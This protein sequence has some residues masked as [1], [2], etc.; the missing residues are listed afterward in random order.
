MSTGHGLHTEQ[1]SWLIAVDANHTTLAVDVFSLLFLSQ[2]FEGLICLEI[3]AAYNKSLHHFK[4]D[5][6]RGR[7]KP[8]Y[9]VG[10]IFHQVVQT[11]EDVP[12]ISVKATWIIKIKPNHLRYY[13][14]KSKTERRIC[15]ALSIVNG[16]DPMIVL[17]LM[18]EV[19][20]LET[21]RPFAFIT[22]ATIMLLSNR[23][24]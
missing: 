22:M 24:S 13:K 23:Q 18:L 9:S 1:G 19:P 15:D 12:G 3:S 11:C 16:F 6:E 7:Y 10:E 4:S 5:V 21:S 17:Y 8:S 20:D 14:R 2:V